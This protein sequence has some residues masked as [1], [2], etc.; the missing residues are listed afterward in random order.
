MKKRLLSAHI[1]QVS[2]LR[3]NPAFFGECLAFRTVP[4][5]ARVVGWPLVSTLRTTVQMTAQ[6]CG[7]TVENGIHRPVLNYGQPVTLA[8]TFTVLL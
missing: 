2:L 1:E 5:T 3:V 8:V 7:T 4:V 6:A